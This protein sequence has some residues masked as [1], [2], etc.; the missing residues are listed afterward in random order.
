M[1]RVFVCGLDTL[2]SFP[3]PVWFRYK[4]ETGQPQGIQAGWIAQDIAP[5]APFM[6][7]EMQ[8]LNGGDPLLTVDYVPML[9]MLFNAVIDLDKRL[10]ELEQ[11]YANSGDP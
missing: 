1:W 3:L 10:A 7:G 2:R 6:I 8:S 9:A 5:V 11:R 4:P